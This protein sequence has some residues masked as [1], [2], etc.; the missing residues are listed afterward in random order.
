LAALEAKLLSR[1]EP[2]GDADEEFLRLRQMLRDLAAA[3]TE[4]ER[5]PQAIDVKTGLQ[6]ELEGKEP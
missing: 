2:L 5:T 6:A 1:V 4:A 3:Q